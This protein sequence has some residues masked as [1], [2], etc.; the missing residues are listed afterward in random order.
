[1]F[2]PLK[3]SADRT[4]SGLVKRAILF[5]Q[6]VVYAYR[7]RDPAYWAELE[8]QVAAWH[9]A[10]PRSLAARL[11]QVNVRF[12]RVNS[13]RGD[14]DWP[15]VPPVDLAESRRLALEAMAW[16]EEVRPLAGDEP[17]WDVARLNLL[18]YVGSTPAQSLEEGLR[19]IDRHPGYLP[20]V[21]TAAWYVDE[22]WHGSRA[23]VERIVRENAARAPASEGRASY[24]RA[25]W[26]LDDNQFHGALFTATDAK[27]SDMKAGFEDMIAVWPAAWNLNAY[28]R[29]AC[30]AHDVAT[31]RPLLARIGDDVV[32]Q[33]W[34][35]DDGT[36]LA[37]C[38]AESAA[39]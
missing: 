6:M 1:M 30:L 38:R 4:P 19:A 27:W 23:M 32:L 9:R 18:P 33:V 25:Y 15:D 13:V 28:A 31:L 24:A 22:D 2:A 8:P 11:F 20:L 39:R 7:R 29:F 14:G 5:H 3:G 34:G 35:K 16:L 36:T 10:F 37:R 17:E 21:T 12:I 26:Y